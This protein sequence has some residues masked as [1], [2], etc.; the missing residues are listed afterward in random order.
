MSG[1]AGTRSGMQAR[2]AKPRLFAKALLAAAL[3]AAA[4]IV[5]AWLI[6]RPAVGG[7]GASGDRAVVATVNGEPVTV[8]EFR[9]LLGKHRASVYG[10]FHDKYAADNTPQFWTTSFGGEVPLEKLKA[11][12]IHES[13]TIKVQQQLAL[14]KGLVADIDFPAFLRKLRAENKRRAAAVAGGQAIYGPSSYDERAYY[15]LTFGDLVAAL[16]KKIGEEQISSDEA[17]RQAYEQNKDA[18]FAKTD[19]QRLR[20]LTVPYTGDGAVS[21]ERAEALIEAIEAKLAAGSEFATLFADYRQAD[22]GP[23]AASE[24]TVDDSTLRNDAV[25]GPQWTDAALRLDAGS[26]SPVIE[27][28]GAFT[29]MQCAER[30]KLGY[31]PFAEAKATVKALLTDQAYERMVAKLVGDADIAINDKVYKEVQA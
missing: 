1:R 14:Q 11:E 26:V 24:R 4:L 27:E 25:S 29:I 13:A 20:Q 5:L 21:R 19:R 28:N 10:Y 8:A 30:V 17:L 6:V 22:T 15:D 31:V 7:G 18:L 3:A 12:A 2:A 23:V 16:K 9:L